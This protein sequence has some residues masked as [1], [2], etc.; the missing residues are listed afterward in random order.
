MFI[1]CSREVKDN[2]TKNGYSTVEIVLVIDNDVINQAV[3]ESY[4]M[5]RGN[6]SM[7]FLLALKIKLSKETRRMWLE[8]R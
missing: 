8:H 1:P 7:N 2:E 4:Q 6:L 5:W 3:S